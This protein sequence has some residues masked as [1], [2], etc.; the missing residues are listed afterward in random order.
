MTA[1][2]INTNFNEEAREE[3]VVEIN[4]IT[5][6]HY[7]LAEAYSVMREEACVDE[8]DSMDISVERVLYEDPKDKLPPAHP[9]ITREM[10][11]ADVSRTTSEA[12]EVVGFDPSS[13]KLP[14]VEVV[15]ALA[16]A[17]KL[18]G[19]GDVFTNTSDIARMWHKK[20]AYSPLALAPQY[21]GEDALP[22]PKLR[23]DGSAP[24][25][26]ESDREFG[27]FIPVPEDDPARASWR[28]HPD[29]IELRKRG[30]HLQHKIIEHFT[31]TEMYPDGSRVRVAA[32]AGGAAWPDMRAVATLTQERPEIRI[33]LDVFD[34]D[35]AAIYLG[36]HNAKGLLT[37]A[38]ED[39][40]RVHEDDVQQITTIESGN[41]KVRFI[42]ADIT[43]QQKLLAHANEGGSNGYDIVEAVGLVEYFTQDMAPFVITNMDSLLKE[44][45]GLGI[46]ANMTEYHN[47]P[48]ILGVIGWRA[49]RPRSLSD[50]ARFVDEGIK[51]SDPNRVP[52]KKLELLDAKSYL[53][54]SWRK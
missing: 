11:L 25:A 5:K 37:G 30:V 21:N 50:I 4:G 42:N 44:K 31:D 34:W 38:S 54:T 48:Q 40:V 22:M 46:V 9:T 19:I 18:D 10:I 28:Y 3:S 13:N 24:Q 41:A 32:I 43:N 26:H 14:P 27:G 33:E 35:K 2:R 52:D 20:T 15:R 39:K 1:E 53:Y 12:L 23:E 49:L 47:H 45:I 29:T 17:G 51:M 6:D 36:V 7:P 8:I 16:K